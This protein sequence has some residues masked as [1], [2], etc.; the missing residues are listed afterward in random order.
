MKRRWLVDNDL[1]CAVGKRIWQWWLFAPC[2]NGAVVD[3]DI[4]YPFSLSLDR[5]VKECSPG[6]WASTIV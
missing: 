1:E 6:N 5:T 3:T 2:K 4:G